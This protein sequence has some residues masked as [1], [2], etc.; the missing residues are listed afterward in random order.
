MAQSLKA[1]KISGTPAK[2]QWTIMVYLAGDN[3]LDGAG[4][5]DLQEMKQ[6]GSNAAMNIVC[7]FDREGAKGT[8][9]RYYVTKGGSV[10]K[11]VVQ[12]LGETNTGDPKVLADFI[13]W[14]AKKY[15]AQ[16]YLFVLWNHG[17]GWDDTNIYKAARGALKLGITRK[18]ASV[19]ATRGSRT[20]AAASSVALGQLRTI[21]N[22]RFRRALFSSTIET[23]IKARAIAF[24]DNAKDFLD[25]VEMK[26]VLSGAKKLFGQKIDILG[27]DA[28]L[29][30][31]AEVAYQVRDSCAITVGSEEVEPGDGWPYH[32]ILGALAAKPKMA[33]SELAK[34]I[35][36]EYI[37]SYGPSEAV[38]QSAL[39]LAKIAALSKALDALAVRLK[40][41]SA[42]EMTNIAAARAQVQSYDTPDYVDLIDLCSLLK[43]RIPLLGRHT[44]DVVAQAQAAIIAN[45]AKGASVRNSNGASIYFPTKGISTL[46]AKLDFAK[47]ARW[48]EF[49][50][51]YQ[52]QVVRRPG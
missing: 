31:M 52:S 51:A 38:T 35:V 44:D 6:V 17:S 11:D 8:T 18:G 50:A 39:D 27:M 48:D 40:D 5:T 10:E 34:V 20:P 47:S 42:T 25:S 29:M 23:A 1:S 41:V 24:D 49:L 7:Q 46:Y 37:R 33:P 45:G 14:S 4:V 32:K 21:S 2:K 9:K 43:A 15:P 12:K 19:G 13:A 16:H 22:K 36:R 28:C 3:N 30:N 26:H